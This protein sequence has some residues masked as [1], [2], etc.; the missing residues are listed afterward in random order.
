MFKRHVNLPDDELRALYLEQGLTMT[1]LA[2]RFGV[3]ESSIRRRLNALLIPTRPRGP[4]GSRPSARIT[5]TPIG[6][7]ALYIEQKL[8]IPQIAEL[9]CC[10]NETI[11]L[12]LIKYGI[13][14]RSFSQA[15]LIQH[16]TDTQLKDFDGDDC[17]KAYMIGFRLGD[18]NVRKDNANSEVLTVRGNSTQY[19]QIELVRQIF[20]RYGHIGVGR[21]IRVARGG[22]LEYHIRCSVNRSFEFLLKYDSELPLWILKNDQVFLAFFGGFTDAEGS[23]HLERQEKSVVRARFTIKNTDKRILEQCREKLLSMGV[24][25]TQINLAYKGGWVSRRGV[26]ARKDLWSLDVSNKHSLVKL[27]LLLSPYLHHPKRRSDMERVQENVEWR[28]S[29]EFQ[30]EAQRKRMQSKKSRS[31]IDK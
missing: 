17:E 13:P 26:R 16:G 12:R 18:L 25:C 21:H 11:R 31:Q 15:T 22:V 23:F 28:D 6:L 8:S 30:L 20:A 3:G 9:Y 14:I 10:A 29:E 1:E 2:A 24:K 19:D 5:L 27:I 7:R 4:M